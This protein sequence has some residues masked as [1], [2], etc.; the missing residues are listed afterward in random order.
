MTNRRQFLGSAVGVPA[1]NR[2]VFGAARARKLKLG[3]IGCG[4]YGMVDLKAA[5]AVGSIECLALCDV[6]SEHLQTSAAETEKLQGSRP[7]TFKD[8]R[9]LLDVD[10]LDAV[11][12]ATPPHWHA[13]MFIDACGKGLA[14][15]EEK[16]L[17]YDV[18]EGRAMVD[19]AA[20]AGNI[21]QIGFQRRQS[22]NFRAAREYIRSGR[23]GR[24][25]QVDVQ[26]HYR[27]NPKDNTPQQPP[28]SLDWDAW[29][30]P[31]PKLPFS[32]N[33]APKT[34]RLEEAY[35]NGHLV[36]WGIHLIDAI[37]F[38]L[39][40]QTPKSVTASGGIYE[41]QGRITTPDTLTANFEFETGPVVWNHRLWGSAEYDPSVNNGI[42]FFGDKETI[43]A[44]DNR[45]MIIPRGKGA[46]RKVIEE[47]GPAA[48]KAHMENF[49]QAVRGQTTVAC[50]PADGYASTTAVQLGMI[51]YKTNSRV[52]WDS[53]SGEIVNNPKAS[54]L[55]LR[56][57]RAPYE[58]PYR[59]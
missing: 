46:A 18:R 25:V 3:L 31:A 16:P 47:K 40:E 8:Y 55:L 56:P 52:E 17:S 7:K 42:F 33:L 21:V 30:G 26:I 23:A 19:A 6:D 50:P 32:P 44:T 43:F 9:E 36:D 2:I 24:I 34:W 10:G 27:A 13:L 11:I 54:S 12:I 45:W 15:Y 58:H 59:S 5:F 48:G 20:K 41:Y 49:L 53:A 29:C 35:G 37:R 14:I 38:T 51:S 28:A 22:P 1:A 57:Y 4:W 39:G